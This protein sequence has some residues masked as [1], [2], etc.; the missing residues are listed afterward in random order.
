MVVNVEYRHKVKQAGDED[1]TR[2][3]EDKSLEMH[4]AGLLLAFHIASVVNDS[5]S[6]LLLEDFEEHVV[7]VTADSVVVERAKLRDHVNGDITDDGKVNVD[8]GPED[9]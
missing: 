7:V 6:V 2:N 4:V 8:T 9:Q 5:R 1:A 3:F